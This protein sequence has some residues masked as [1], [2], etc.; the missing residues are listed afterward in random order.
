[1]VQ[2]SGGIPGGRFCGMMTRT[3]LSLRAIILLRLRRGTPFLPTGLFRLLPTLRSE[4]SPTSR[5]AALRHKAALYSFAGYPLERRATPINVAHCAGPELAI[6]LT[7]PRPRSTG[8]SRQLTLSSRWCMPRKQRADWRPHARSG[9]RV[10]S[11]LPGAPG[12]YQFRARTHS[13]VRI[14]SARP[15]LV[16]VR[17]GHRAIEMSRANA[18]TGSQAAKGRGCPVSYNVFEYKSVRSATTSSY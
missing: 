9:R 3:I 2:H 13:M 7:R 15:S 14:R 1:M 18:R 11:S 6:S 17:W 4:S 5:V 10:R 12:S 8:S 16:G